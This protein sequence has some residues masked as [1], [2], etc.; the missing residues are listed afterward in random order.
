MGPSML[1]IFTTFGILLGKTM[2][3]YTPGQNP[4]AANHR[5]PMVK[6]GAVEEFC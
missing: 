1:P 6:E 5:H 3:S 4:P 2:D